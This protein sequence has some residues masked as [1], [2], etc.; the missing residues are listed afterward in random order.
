MLSNRKGFRSL[1]SFGHEMP[2]LRIELVGKF[3]SSCVLVILHDL[4]DVRVN[5]LM[6]NKLH[7]LRR[8]S[9]C[10]SS[11]SSEMPNIGFASSSASRRRAS[12]MPS[13][14]SWRTDG[15]DPSK[16]AARTAL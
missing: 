15:S 10:W 2:Q 6:Q 16:C 14:S 13:S 4:V 12:A 11:C 5:L 1:K 9:I 8:R 7:Q 3:W